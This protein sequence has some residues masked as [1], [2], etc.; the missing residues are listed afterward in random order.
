MSGKGT[1]GV[2]VIGLGFMGGTHIRAYSAARAAGH[3]CRLVAVCDCDPQ[4]LAGRTSDAGNIDL[5]GGQGSFDLS[6]VRCYADA[7]GLL[8]DDAVDLVSVCTHTETHVDLGLRAIEAG[9]HVLV[10]KPVALLSSDVRVL[11]E[12]AAAASTLCMPAMCIRFWPG[13]AWLKEQ[14]VNRTYGP[15]RSAVFHRLAVP[16]DWSP[17]FYRNPARTGGALVDLHIHD[18]DFIRWCFGQPDSVASTGSIDH[19]TTIYRYQ[20]GPS[21]V[22]AEGGWDHAPGFPFNMR[23]VVG[24]ERAT[25]EYDLRGDDPLAVARN[26]KVETIK[27]EPL[28]GYDGQ[29]R[30]LLDA[31]ANNRTHTRV[32]MKDAVETAQ[33]LEAERQSIESGESVRFDPST[34]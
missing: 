18:A 24:F 31:I 12:A 10:E 9:K 11:A 23:Y 4:C 32:T 20:S 3:D 34:T 8:G 16:P 6:D 29:V 2:G 15:V 13:W 14:I 22:V 17:E 25:A 30:H 1:I 26:G 19:L 5:G 27:L 7:E 28:T 21:H 33:L